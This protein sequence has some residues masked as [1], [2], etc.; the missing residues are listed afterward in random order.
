MKEFIIASLLISCVIAQRRQ[1]HLQQQQQQVQQQQQ[2]VQQQQQP[3]QQVPPF[4]I[5]ESQDVIREFERL[6]AS[7]AQRTDSEM[8]RLIESWI[9][10][11]SPKVQVSSLTSTLHKFIKTKQWICKLIKF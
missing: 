5:G 1:Q 4:L 3:I 10:Q 2:Q 6:L 9:G 8:E 7:G 11:R